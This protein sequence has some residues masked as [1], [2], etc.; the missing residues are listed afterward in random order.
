MRWRLLWLG[1]LLTSGV[2]HVVN[3]VVSGDSRLANWL[4]E[5]QVPN[6]TCRTGNKASGRRSERLQSNT[7]AEI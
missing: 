6:E 7:R 5:I 4:N 3:V 2:H 1:C